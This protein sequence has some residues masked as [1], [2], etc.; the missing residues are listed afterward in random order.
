MST[1]LLLALYIN[2]FHFILYP[3]ATQPQNFLVSIL[4]FH[5]PFNLQFQDTEP[6]V[7]CVASKL[8]GQRYELSIKTGVWPG[9][10]TTANVSLIIYGVEGNSG[11]IKIHQDSSTGCKS[12]FAR[13]TEQKFAVVL[14]E[15]VGEIYS[16][17]V[18]HDSSG[19]DPS[20]FLDEITI[21]NPNSGDCWKFIFETWL[22]LVDESMS[23]EVLQTPSFSGPNATSKALMK[24]FS[25]GHLWFSI[26]TKTPGDCFTRVQTI[27]SCL[28]L[29]FC[30][31]AANAA[32]FYW[33]TQ[34]YQ[35]INLGPLTFSARQAI[36]SVQSNILILPL[37]VI[38]LLLKT[39]SA[40]LKGEHSRRWLCLFYVTCLLCAM[41]TVTSAAVTVFYSIMWGKEKSQQWLS[42][43][44]ISFFQDILIVQPCK[45]ILL[46]SVTVMFSKCKTKKAVSNQQCDVEMP[47]KKVTKH[48]MTS[49]ELSKLT[50]ESVAK[51]RRRSSIS[52]GCFYCV[53]LV[54]IGVL[55]YGNRD[56]ARY[57]LSKSLDDHIGN[58]EKV[59]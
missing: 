28:C 10:G 4:S 14:N 1:I 46:A 31:M 25:N 22:S 21:S 9:A 27:S 49:T 5:L 43:V 20:W 58:F 12:N 16:L 6:P 44:T 40:R 32:F 38:I 24:M 33:G 48:S 23:N 13:A 3:S 54:V 41:M 2:I 53:F 52:Q 19:N 56:S 50:N 29:L 57:M 37:H 45:C 39:S 42:S 55:S 30:T 17:R 51:A 8:E 47:M 34:S 35:T 59:K 26:L 18:W 11:T 7:I 36:V 15:D